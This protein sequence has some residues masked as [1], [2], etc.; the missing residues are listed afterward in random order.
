MSK[1]LKF[2]FI[3]SQQ[4]LPL[5]YVFASSPVIAQIVPDATLPNQSNVTTEGTTTLIEGGTQAG[6]NLFHSFEQFS[7]PTGN[8]AYFNNGADVQN[9]FSR[10]TGSSISNIDSLIKANGTAD[11]FFINPNGIIFGPNAKLDIGGSFISSTASSL[12]FADG[13]EFNATELQ[14]ETLLS[15]SVPIG[16][17]FTSHS[18]AINVQGTGHNLI[19]NN[20]FSPF[21]RGSSSNGLQVKPGNTLAVV[22]GD[23]ALE[24]GKLEANGGRIELGSVDKGVVRLNSANGGWALGYES[25]SSFKN[26]KIAKQSLADASGFSGGVIQVQ[27]AGIELSNGSIFL[28]QN[29]GSESSGDITVNTSDVLKLIGTSSN[30]LIPTGLINETLGGNGGEIK[31]SANKLILQD[32]AAI[33][34]RSYSPGKGGDLDINADDSIQVNGASSANLQIPSS[35]ISAAFGSGDGGNTKLSTKNLVV[36]GGGEIL[37][38]TYGAGKGGNLN[39]NVLNSTQVL[40][41]LSGN[42]P[43]SSTILT[44]TYGSEKGGHLTLNTGELTA[45]D[46]GAIGS[47]TVGNNQGGDV[48]INAKNSIELTGVVPNIFSPSSLNAI[49]FS[50]GNAGRLTVNTTKLLV[51]DSGRVYTSTLAGGNA[52]QLIINASES[53]E[54]NGKVPESTNP[55]LIDSS[56]NIAERNLQNLYKL[57]PVPSGNSGNVVINTKNLNITNSGLVSVKNDGK[58]NAGSLQIDVKTLNLDKAG[59]L[60]AASASGE[61]GDIFVRSQFLQLLNGSSITTNVAGGM[62]NGGN[63]AINTNILTALNG[64]SITADAVQGRGGNIVVDTD[65]LFLSPNSKITATSQLGINGT[66][67]INSLISQPT[68]GLIE[69]PQQALDVTN[70]VAQGCPANV[71]SEPTS[72]V[73]IGPGGL[74]E[75][76]YQPLNVGSVWEDLRQLPD[77]QPHDEPITTEPTEA[78]TQET[79]NVEPVTMVEASSLAYNNQGEVML[80]ASLPKTATLPLP[81]C[82]NF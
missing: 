12:K 31:I 67:Q 4:L 28:I 2:Y 46:G 40:N 44:T 61:G 26:I 32:G 14:S 50:N 30:G 23:L 25:A 17:G 22:G 29:L 71:A 21:T 72:F 49:T 70:L 41:Y 62:G 47:L 6:S 52:G 27:G 73:V 10:V 68:N 53:V 64:S 81:Q 54:V 35:V 7:T 77:N 45:K 74:P 8:T 78:N 57:P 82:Q 51:R 20:P 65:G 37:T 36:Q 58:G 76:P 18:G 80:V 66:V 79:A 13:T 48:T 55:S 56:A 5:L 75:N 43:F 33:N 39:V 69:L 24:G 19:L 9:I 60:T 16:L 15:I 11:L 1:S 34:T 3:F 42:F 38:A 63:I 59:S